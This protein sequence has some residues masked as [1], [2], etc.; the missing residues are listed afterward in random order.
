L[1]EIVDLHKRFGAE[2]VLRGVNLAIPANRITAIIG[3]SG[4]GKSVLFKLIVGLLAPD[5]GRVLVEGEDVA[6]LGPAALARVREKFGFLF[7]G[8]ALFDSL[9]VWDNLAF[10]L[11]EKTALPEP[12][13]ARRVDAGLAEVGLAG[14]GPKYPAELSG[15]MLKR[16]A[17]ARS[18]IRDPRVALFDEPTTGL[19]PILLHSMQRLIHRAWKRLG[20]TGVLVSHDVPEVSE[21]AET[22][23][24]LDRG[25]VVESG[26]SQAVLGSR[27]PVVRRFLSGGDAEER[28]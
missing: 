3:P 5:R 15:G 6:R 23:A 4:G 11:R 21:I 19:D 14:M 28:S 13:I 24:V 17:L 1:I 22:I 20:F 2:E 16:A 7:Q 8:G 25:V 12:E 9:T 27:N 18:L 26:P 10:P